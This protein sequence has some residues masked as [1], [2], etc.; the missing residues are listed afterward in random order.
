MKRG[1]QGGRATAPSSSSDPYLFSTARG[2]GDELESVRARVSSECAG[3]D[4]RT[5]LVVPRDVESC[6]GRARG[7]VARTF[8]SRSSFLNDICTDA[9]T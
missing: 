5:H 9:D 8:A 3:N 6:V 4:V 1:A 2:F 7:E